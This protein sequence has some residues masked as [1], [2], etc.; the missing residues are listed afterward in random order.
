[1]SC[2]QRFRCG[3]LNSD[4][5]VTVPLFDLSSHLEV[6]A[7]VLVDIGGRNACT[8]GHVCFPLLMWCWFSAITQHTHSRR[9]C[10]LTVL[11]CVLFRH[12]VLDGHEEHESL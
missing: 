2:A 6:S 3:A 11:T 8:F 7:S 5:M 12:F 4:Q 9:V 1:M 10:W